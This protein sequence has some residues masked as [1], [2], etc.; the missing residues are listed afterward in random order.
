MF[1]ILF[2]P[3]LR[4]LFLAVASD[5]LPVATGGGANVDS[6]VNF[7][8]SG[9]Q[10]NGFTAGI[11]QSIQINK[12]HRQAS[13]VA[14]ALTNFI[15]NVLGINIQDDGN[16]AG[17]ITNLTKAIQR[18]SNILAV[19]VFSGTPVFDASTANVFEITLTGNVTSSTLSNV[20]PGQEL[21]FIIHQDGAGAHT[22]VPPANL[23]LA[24]ISGGANKTSVQQFIVGNSLAVYPVGP[25]TVT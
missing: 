19:I 2:R 11:A 13:M 24:P 21:A 6:Q 16:L 25:M 1:N 7:S 5:Y 14:A 18:G 9:Y 8:G 15:V 3:Y 10:V 17:L 4:A 22:F 20:A 12:V 23:P